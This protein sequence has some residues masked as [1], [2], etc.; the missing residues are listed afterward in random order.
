[1]KTTDKIDFTTL[2]HRMVETDLKG[3]GIADQRVLAAMSEVP[4]E[5][6]V[7]DALRESAYDDRALPIGL[8]QTISQP[9]TVAF[10]LESL[11]LRDG[12]KVLEIGTGSGYVVHSVEFLPEL[13]QVAERRLH[14]LG[15]FNVHVHVA[16]GS[17]GL[18]EQGPFDAI[19][20]TAA[21]E[22][23]PPPFAKQLVESGRLVLPLGDAYSQSL[24]RF[25]KD[26]DRLVSENLGGFVFVPLVGRYGR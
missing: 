12:N 13:A 24:Y 18:P 1:M 26:G 10:M 4:R 7:P 17:L 20:V 2:R 8:H 11:G 19:V 16:D 22:V 3:R 9:Y 5:E 15:F 6:F 25:T 23:L 21:A 14:R